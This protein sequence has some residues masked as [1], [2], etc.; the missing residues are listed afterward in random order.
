MQRYILGRLLLLIPTL[1]GV[2]L[3]IFVIMRMLP[4]DVAVVAL[5]GGQGVSE[6]QI[7]E[8]RKE[9]G[10]DRPLVVQYLD[11]AGGLLRLDLGTSLLTKQPIADDIKNRLPVTAELAIATVIVS[12][13]IAVPIGV[14]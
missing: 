2:S 8:Y 11:W 12:T 5:G 1:F 4:G 7:K 10:L 14:L 3:I 13:L 9:L 6:Q